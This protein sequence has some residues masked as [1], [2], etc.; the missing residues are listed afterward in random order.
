MIRL[1]KKELEEKLKLAMEFIKSAKVD[2]ERL[3]YAEEQR[4]AKSP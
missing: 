2:K 4:R 1:K 3:V